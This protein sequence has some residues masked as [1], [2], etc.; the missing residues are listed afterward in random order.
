MWA[1]I[2]VK[3]SSNFL[4]VGQIQEA[5]KSPCHPNNIVFLNNGEVYNNSITNVMFKYIGIKLIITR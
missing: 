4:F 5:L 2:D 1:E 3:K